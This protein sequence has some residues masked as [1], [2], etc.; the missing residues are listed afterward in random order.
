MK[1][2]LEDLL[3]TLITLAIIFAG[4]TAVLFVAFAVYFELKGVIVVWSSILY[5]SLKASGYIF[6]A[7]F[8]LMGFSTLFAENKEASNE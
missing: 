5:G 8:A 2:N 1:K 7:G 3:G 6:I 4:I